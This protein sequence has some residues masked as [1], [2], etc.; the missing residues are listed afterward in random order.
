MRRVAVLLLLVGLLAP[1]LSGVGGVASAEG[2]QAQGWWW[3]LHR[4]GLPAPPP[5]PDVG[6]D[7]LLVQ[8]GDVQRLLEPATAP[9]PTALAALV[10]LVPAEAEV[11][12]LVLQVAPGAQA[13]DVRAYPAPGPWEAAQGGAIEQAPAADLTRFAPGFL[14]ADGAS[15]S[16]PEAGSLL[17][18]TGV[19]S[20]V[21][22]AG[23]LD[24]VV[25]HHPGTTA[26]QVSPATPPGTAVPPP[27]PP[28]PPPGPPRSGA[29]RPAQSAPLPLD[30][31][32]L[33]PT[34]APVVPVVPVTPA[35][36]S[37]AAVRRVVTDD[38]RTRVVVLLEA[39]LLLSFFGLLGQ[40]PLAVLGRRLGSAAAV[41]AERGVGR[42]RRP[43]EGPVPRL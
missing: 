27:S 22:V 37:T 9:A 29:V 25:F 39:L 16:F 4:A 18:E 33:V 34:A 7:D 6:P 5:P 32:L 2:A 12:A 19:L 36:G 26:L 24:R 11:G 35:T 41:P 3:A 20:V 17:G 8:G 43:R 10:F 23:P 21:L 1:V 38:G 14:S 13:A 42:F 40:G 31:P 15:L 30:G 28:S